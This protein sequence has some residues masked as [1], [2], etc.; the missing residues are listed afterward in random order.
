MKSQAVK[1][2]EKTLV[3]FPGKKS[4]LNKEA[5]IIDQWN[6]ELLQALKELSSPL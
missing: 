6:E 3:Q 4:S 1:V 5:S 2:L